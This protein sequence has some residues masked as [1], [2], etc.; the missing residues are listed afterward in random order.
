MGGINFVWL[1]V[2][3]LSLDWPCRKLQVCSADLNAIRF[4]DMTI[5]GDGLDWTAGPC[6]PSLTRQA[7]GSAL[8]QRMYLPSCVGSEPFFTIYIWGL[9]RVSLWGKIIFYLIECTKILKSLLNFVR[10][11]TLIQHPK[12]IS[13]IVCL[14]FIFLY[15]TF[16]LSSKSICV[17]VYTPIAGFK[18]AHIYRRL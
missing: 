14:Y 13:H 1:A 8:G 2:W 7:T 16:Y 15:L 4:V 6:R 9:Q 11:F 5:A 3:F 12:F 17:N 10:I 18:F